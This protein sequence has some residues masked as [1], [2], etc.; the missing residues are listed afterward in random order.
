[1]K[2]RKEITLSYD[3]DDFNLF[4]CDN[5]KVW[6]FDENYY[7]SKLEILELFEDYLLYNIKRIKEKKKEKQIEKNNRNYIKE[8]KKSINM[9]FRRKIYKNKEITKNIIKTL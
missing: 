2:E 4:I 8:R 9:I 7:K 6:K 3:L 5:K 1:M